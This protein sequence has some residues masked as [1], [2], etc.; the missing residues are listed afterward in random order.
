MRAL[1][2]DPEVRYLAMTTFLGVLA[3]FTPLSA[4]QFVVDDAAVVE[5]GACQLEGWWGKEESWILPGCQFVP[6]ME[7]TVGLA[8]F[9]GGRGSSTLHTVFEGKVLV[10]AVEARSWGWGI[11]VGAALP[12]EDGPRPADGYAFVPLT[13]TLPRGGL[14]LHA[15]LGWGMEREWLEVPAGEP[16]ADP[17]SE[18][19]Q[20]LLWGLRVD[21][22]FTPRVQLIGELFG[23]TGDGAQ[24]QAGLRTELLPDRLAFDLSYGEHLTAGEPGFGFQ[25]GLAWTPP[26]FR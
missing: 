26:P 5:R 9:D 11:V 21:A 3:A 14:T 22:D 23:L 17:T 13:T 6:D 8:F 18:D 15:N 2:R 1:V 19:H 24:A 20:G 10:R 16:N 4:Q 25:V 12:L 7:T